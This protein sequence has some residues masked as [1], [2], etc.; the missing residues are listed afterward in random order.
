MEDI[1]CLYRVVFDEDVLPEQHNHE[2]RH[3]AFYLWELFFKEYKEL[4][5]EKH[6]LHRECE[7]ARIALQQLVDHSTT[8]SMGNLRCLERVMT[9]IRGSIVT[10][11]EIRSI[12]ANLSSPN[13]GNVT[14]FNYVTKVNISDEDQTDT[15]ADLNAVVHLYREI[16]KIDNGEK[17]PLLLEYEQF[18]DELSNVENLYV[19]QLLKNGLI[20]VKKQLEDSLYG[21]FSNNINSTLKIFKDINRLSVS[22]SEEIARGYVANRNMYIIERLTLVKSL[23][24]ENVH[25]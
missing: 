19:I 3:I 2:I 21:S 22:S 1:Q 15:T 9:E 5:T 8:T 18:I 6:V 13:V 4:K 20:K 12:S 23:M 11:E 25:R 7:D 17:I 10:V 16:L 24:R 14:P